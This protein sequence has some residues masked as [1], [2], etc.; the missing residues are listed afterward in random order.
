VRIFSLNVPAG[1]DRA[2]ILAYSSP[3]Q[4]YALVGAK[5][6]MNQPVP[7]ALNGGSQVVLGPADAVTVY[8]PIT[9]SNAPAAYSAPVTIADYIMSGGRGFSIGNYTTSFP[10]FPSGAAVGGDFYETFAMAAS[11]AKPTEMMILAKSFTSAGP[12][13]F[14]FPSPWPYAGPQPAALPTFDLSYAGFG[15]KTGVYEAAYMDWSKPTVGNYEIY[16]V[17][18]SNYLNGAAAL[19]VPDLSALPGFLA[20]PSAGTSVNWVALIAQDSAG[21]A[22]PLSS[23]ATITTVENSGTYTVP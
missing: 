8:Q 1:N 19:A 17:A 16:V 13:S 11:S 10:V 9:Y 15:G 6:L 4:G 14:A 20:P 23:S 5:S 12:L 22:M 2:L 3:L 21:I 7:G 18:S